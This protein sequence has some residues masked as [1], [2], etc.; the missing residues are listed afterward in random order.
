LS[1]TLPKINLFE[2]VTGFGEGL[3]SQAMRGTELGPTYIMVLGLE[4]ALAFGFGT[5]IFGR[6]DNGEKN[7]CH[8]ADCV[9]NCIAAN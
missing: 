1:S 2:S 8:S 4:A 6:I 5:F 3:Q 7:R 9:R